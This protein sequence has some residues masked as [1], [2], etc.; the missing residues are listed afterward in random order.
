MNDTGLL[1]FS[2]LV[3]WLSLQKVVSLTLITKVFL[4]RPVPKPAPQLKLQTLWQIE[5]PQLRKAWTDTFFKIRSCPLY[6]LFPNVFSNNAIFK[7]IN[8]H[9]QNTCTCNCRDWHNLSSRASSLDHHYH[10]QRQVKRRCHSKLHEE[11]ICTNC[12]NR[13]CVQQNSNIANTG[14][15]NL[16]I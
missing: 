1:T 5:S 3:G 7:H 8:W 6:C 16:S 10:N 14:I 2:T 9:L 11:F 13:I 15:T 4:T 12:F